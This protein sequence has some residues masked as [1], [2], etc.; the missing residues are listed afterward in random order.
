MAAQ[1][2][3][4]PANASDVPL[5][6]ARCFRPRLWWVFVIF[7][8]GGI[9]LTAIGAVLGSHGVAGLGLVAFAL[10]GVGFILE[11]LLLVIE[12][13]LLVIDVVRRV[14]PGRNWMLRLLGATV[15][16][17]G[18]VLAVY[19]VLWRPMRTLRSGEL[20]G[21][22]AEIRSLCHRSLLWNPKPHDE[23][24]DLGFYGDESSV[25]YIIWALRWM[26]KDGARECTWEHG[27]EALRRITHHSAGS[28]RET[29]AQ[30][31]AANKHRTLEQWRA[32]AL[33]TRPA[34]PADDME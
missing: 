4:S 12:W 33:T 25:P 23:F 15:C 10:A 24:Q 1:I 13:L 19:L 17:A 30:W 29:W 6:P 5:G 34:T 3:T 28:S 2:D 7:G 22:P 20:A 14:G 18:L 31:Y 8:A 21:T 11:W 26:P 9:V 16:W 32:D 27:L